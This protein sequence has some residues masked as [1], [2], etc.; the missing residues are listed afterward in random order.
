[1]I[2]L[3][4]GF[5][6]KDDGADSIDRARVYLEDK[7]F[8]V[9]DIDYG[10]F[11][12]LR[13]RMC[14]KGLAKVM[15]TLVEPGSTC[16]AHSNG[17]ALAYLACEFGAPFKNVVLVNPALDSTKAL[18]AQVENVQVWYSPHDKWTGLS[19]FIPNSIW[20]AQGRTG[21]TGPEDSRYVQYNNEELLGR[22]KDEHSGIWN[23]S[24]RREYFA[25]KVAALVMEIKDDKV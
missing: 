16:I 5:N 20:G 10:Y 12:R 17:G 22:F 11:Q 4:H 1:M 21:Y 24:E 18:A 2:Y 6:V 25:G 23:T 3:I 8:E 15:S 9:T 14:N 13:V 7:D 19:K